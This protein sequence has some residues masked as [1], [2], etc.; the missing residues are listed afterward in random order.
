MHKLKVILGHSYIEEKKSNENPQLSEEE[1]SNCTKFINDWKNNETIGGWLF[2]DEPKLSQISVNSKLYQL[3]SLIKS[4]DDRHLIYIN[5]YGG[6]SGVDIEVDIEKDE[7]DSQY[8]I[9]RK[10]Y[11]LY[12]D[13]FQNVF[14]PSYFCYDLYP[15]ILNQKGE[16]E[17]NFKT[18]YSDLDIFSDLSKK[19]GRPFWV[20]IQSMAFCNGYMKNF[21]PI[22]TLPLLRFA[23]FSALGYGAQGIVY[24]TY[25]QRENTTEEE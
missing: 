18:F 19:T 15:F 17:P 7:G 6:A 24:W 22:A 12:V 5:L 3:Y 1:I 20:F 4:I 21:H 25:H 8:Q 11:N 16:L 14:R 2:K 10:K 9:E 23:V 13:T